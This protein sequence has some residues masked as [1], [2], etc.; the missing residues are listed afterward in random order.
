MSIT[1]FIFMHI[2]MGIA[3]I[4][5]YSKLPKAL[6][7]FAFVSVTMSFLYWGGSFSAYF[8]ELTELLMEK[9]YKGVVKYGR[10]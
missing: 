9:H 6:T 1:L 8:S 3:L 4:Y 10:R 5:F 2:L 7:T